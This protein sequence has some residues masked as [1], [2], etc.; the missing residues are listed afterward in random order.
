MSTELEK[1]VARLEYRE[2][3]IR[4]LLDPRRDPFAF[5]AFENN[6]DELDVKGI[7]EVMESAR[8][9]LSDGKPLETADFVSELSIHI[10]AKERPEGFVHDFVK[11]LLI[12]FEMTGQWYEVVNHFRTEYNIPPRE[13]LMG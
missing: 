10:P 2:S 12:A 11:R 7:E 5:F 8:K 6:L 1:R 13:R 3:L 9:T 4:R